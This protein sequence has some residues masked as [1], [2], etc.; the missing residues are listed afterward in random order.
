VKL[1]GLAAR[2]YAVRNFSEAKM[3]E[4]ILEVLEYAAS[5]R[6]EALV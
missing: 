5:T 2:E 3:A 6:T 1:V 4:R